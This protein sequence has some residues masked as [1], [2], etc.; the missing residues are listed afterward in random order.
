MNRIMLELLLQVNETSLLG[1]TYQEALT[2]LRSA[3][4]TV[5]L[6]V[7]D[8]YNISNEAAEPATSLKTSL[9]SS[10][11][12]RDDEMMNVIRQVCIAYYFIFIVF[13]SSYPVRYAESECSR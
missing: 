4:D 13:H 11:I 1:A 6:V 3:C 2:A 8:G 7:C 5:R 12:D 10:S 9:S